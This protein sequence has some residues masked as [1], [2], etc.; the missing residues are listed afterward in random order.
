MSIGTEPRFA[1]TKDKTASV[2][3]RTY[4]P[5]RM[6][7]AAVFFMVGFLRFLAKVFAVAGG[8]DERVCTK[9]VVPAL[10]DPPIIAH[11][12]PPVR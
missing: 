10:I 6:H 12:P 8:A 7:F 11:T 1:T 3:S 2:G 4:V 5:A 9:L